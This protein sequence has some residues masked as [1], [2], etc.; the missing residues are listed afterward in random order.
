MTINSLKDLQKLVQLCRKQGIKAIEVDGI[1]L[2]LGELP[3]NPAKITD[4]FPE[5]N[6]FDPG[7]I[8]ENVA[9]DKIET[10]AMSEDDMLY[11]SADSQEA[12]S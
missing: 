7:Q 4:V 1:K 6:P 8:E 10:D 12:I 9:P 11:W 2:Q 3:T 5:V